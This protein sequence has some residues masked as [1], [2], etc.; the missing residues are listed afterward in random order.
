MSGRGPRTNNIAGDWR[1]VGSEVL[2]L[3]KLCATSEI[4]S[5]PSQRDVS[6]SNGGQPVQEDGT[7]D[8]VEGCAENQ[9]AE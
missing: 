9:D 2:E 3:N 1:E 7:R 4:G 8:R 5:Q 6:D